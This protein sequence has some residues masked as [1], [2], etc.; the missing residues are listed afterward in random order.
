MLITYNED[1]KAS[2]SFG[3]GIDRKKRLEQIMKEGIF[4]PDHEPH[5]CN[6]DYCGYED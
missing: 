5:E 3:V 6:C 1:F 4:I 2:L